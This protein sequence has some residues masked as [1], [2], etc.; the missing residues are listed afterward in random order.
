MKHRQ[1]SARH[2]FTLV[3]LLTVIAIIGLL[4]GMLQPSLSKAGAVSRRR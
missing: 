2:T 3:E 1:P 4:T